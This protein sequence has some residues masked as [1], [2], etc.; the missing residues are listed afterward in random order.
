MKVLKVISNII[1]KLIGIINIFLIIIIVLNLIHLILLK[2]Q[3]NDY[4]SFMDYTYVIVDEPND[5]LNFKEEDFVLIDLKQSA[6][7]E[8]MV[9]FEEDEETSIGKI[10]DIGTEAVK[11]RNGGIEIEVDKELVLGKVIKVIPT[12]GSVVDILLQT[13]NL[14]ISAVTL[15]ITSIIQTI[16]SKV[17]LKEKKPDFKKYNNLV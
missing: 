4:I 15:V 11:I 10:T 2:V 3:N 7:K 6:M 16:L 13:K 14:L 8:E 17:K 1:Q 5:Y 12:L 9:L